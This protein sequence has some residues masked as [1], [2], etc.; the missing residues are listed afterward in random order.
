MLVSHQASISWRIYTVKKPS[1]RVKPCAFTL[2]RV[3]D[4][5]QPCLFRRGY[6]SY[7]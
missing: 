4:R 1:I 7:E 6:I 5:V 3:S 2:N